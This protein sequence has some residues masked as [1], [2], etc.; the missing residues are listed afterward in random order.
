VAPVFA[1]PRLRVCLLWRHTIDGQR[2]ELHNRSTIGE[3]ASCPSLQGTKASTIT[4][5]S[6][7]PVLGFEALSLTN[8]KGLNIWKAF[9]PAVSVTAP[10][11]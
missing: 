7:N 5:P 4:R 3:R 6:T 8:D 9:C 10:W 1:W 11:V 2:F